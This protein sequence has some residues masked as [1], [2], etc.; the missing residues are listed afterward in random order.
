MKD[1]DPESGVCV[2]LM[3]LSTFVGYFRSVSVQMDVPVTIVL[4]FVG[5]NSEG[6]SQRPYPDTQ[7]H[8]SHQPFTPGGEALQW[9]QIA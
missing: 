5:V 4:M 2:V 3:C 6:F 7:Q 9:Q 8:H 1:S